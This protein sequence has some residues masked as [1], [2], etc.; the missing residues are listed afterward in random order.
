MVF[1]LFV[2]MLALI[3]LGIPISF[4][5]ALSTV[6]TIVLSIDSLPL[7]LVVQ[8][9]FTG[10][11]SFP[12]MCI[13]FFM[14]AGELMSA[15]D[16]S[17]KLVNLANVVVGR[18]R[19]G[20]AHINVLA[21]M[22]FGGVS[23]SACADATSI[24][25]ILIPTMIKAGYERD[26]SVAVTASAGTLGII[27]PPSNPMIVYATVAGSVSISALFLAGIIP[28]ILIGISF[29]FVAYM[30][31]VKRGYKRSEPVQW[32]QVPRIVAEGCVPL[33]T[34][35]IILGGILGGIF[36]PT[37]SA[38]VAAFYSFVIAV[39]VFKTVKLS[40]MPTI[41]FNSALSTS[42]VL[43][44][45]GVSSIFGWLLAYAHIPEEIAAFIF[46][47][48]T[49]K[50]V[51]YTLIY[52]A[53]LIIGTFMEGT[54][55]IIIFTPIFLPIA[56]KL[57]MDPVQFG[58]LI[59]ASFA[60]GN[61]T[62]PVGAVLFVTCALGKISMERAVKALVPFLCMAIIVTMLIIFVPALTMYIPNLMKH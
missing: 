31:S 35:V 16:I 41:L 11:D 22:L 50:Y 40:Q 29:M 28:G 32:R 48:S 45:I 24:G 4:A 49:N 15:G 26:F 42:V 61:Y 57:G 58:V 37:E 9:I 30:I 27:I 39:F 60:I 54:P 25:S 33:F 8:R 10:M 20:L 13:P 52:I 38:V 34:F 23:G 59:V 18:I 47:L 44:L 17:Q 62:P 3:G 1:I 55:A 14:L 36:T 43:L 56:V 2:S 12:I 53:L 21:C 7:T 5:I 51:V 46:S 6:F 19:G